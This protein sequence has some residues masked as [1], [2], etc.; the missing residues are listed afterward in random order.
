ML[1]NIIFFFLYLVCFTVGFAQKHRVFQH[2]ELNTF[3]Q[4]HKTIAILP[5]KVTIE[6]GGKR[7]EDSLAYSLRQDAQRES[8]NIPL[9]CVLLWVGKAQENAP[10]LKSWDKTRLSLAQMGYQPTDNITADTLKKIAKTLQVDA[11]LMGVIN[12]YEDKYTTNYGKSYVA[13]EEVVMVYLSLYDGETGMLLWQH[14]DSSAY[15][16]RLEERISLGKNVE[17]VLQRMFE[18]LPYFKGKKKRK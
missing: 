10:A 15:S 18:I 5:F 8:Y 16:L 17:L 6:Q 12:Q 11:L 7:S 13:S 4:K 14:E 2:K 9:T 3:L 1:R